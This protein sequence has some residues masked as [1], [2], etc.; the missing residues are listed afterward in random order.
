MRIMRVFSLFTNV[1]YDLENGGD[2]E[3]EEVSWNGMSGFMGQ[4]GLEIETFQSESTH[5]PI[6][7]SPFQSLYYI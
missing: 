1:Q 5:L 3:D 4:L 2:L 7:K 6:S